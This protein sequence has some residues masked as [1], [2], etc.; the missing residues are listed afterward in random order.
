MLQEN[1][2]K[3][4]ITEHDPVRE[5]KKENP[6]TRSR[7]LRSL[8]ALMVALAALAPTVAQA[9]L[10]PP[11]LPIVSGPFFNFQP[12]P[13]PSHDLIVNAPLTANALEADAWD[14]GRRQEAEGRG[15]RQTETGYGAGL[16]LYDTPNVCVN[17]NAEDG[18]SSSDGHP[19]MYTDWFSGWAPFALNEGEYKPT[20][21]AVT[22]ERSVGPGDRY[23]D[24]E[25]TDNHT[26]YAIKF[27]GHLPYAAGMGSPRIPVPADFEMGKVM[28]SVK[29]L[30]WDH[31]QGA[32]DKVGDGIDYDWASLGIKPG[33]DG[34]VAL[35]NNGYVRGEWSELVHTIDLG[36]AK[37]IMVL[38]Q[39][40]S[41]AYLNSNIYF[42]DI[43]IAFIAMD[44]TTR[45]MQDCGAV[46]ALK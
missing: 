45:Y 9:A 44:G 41:P 40:Q 21:V 14:A 32:K 20:N 23:N 6:M 2:H 35:Y 25:D 15:V 39:A 5:D 31:D 27:G 12:V 10:T 19:D 37:D 46:E 11:P 18:W 24:T 8:L 1:L 3:K 38:I 13:L 17:F 7:I 29:Y 36:D 33:A 42:D 22:R 26:E 16:T 4:L 43:K 30:I 28:V 34:D